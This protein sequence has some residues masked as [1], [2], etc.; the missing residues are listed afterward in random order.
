MKI[1]ALLLLLVNL[2][3]YAFSAGYLGG[4]SS[5][6]AGRLAQQV[7]P[8][9][10]VIVGHGDASASAKAENK[11]APASKADEAGS[12]EA[13][14]PEE[15][16]PEP[17][18]VEE[19]KATPPAEEPA[20]SESKP[21]AGDVAMTCRAWDKVTLADAEK[22]STA[23]SSKF[24]DYQ[25]TRKASGG[26]DGAAWWVYIPTLA[27]KAEADKKASELRLFGVGD[28]FVV[29]E[30]P[31]RNAIS[32]GI[33]S[34]EKG[35]QERLTEL[36]G[37]GVRSARVGARPGKEGFFLIEAYGPESGMARLA[38][39]V[40]KTLPKAQAQSCQ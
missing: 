23:T 4:Q 34:L 6:E 18:K 26:N 35:A 10:I 16:K 2:V 14:K 5:P 8:E 7:Q 21:V 33:F 25:W 29:Q 39:V 9:K 20:R 1:L 32:L 3:F 30:G 22:L 31:N 11:D 36:K 28:F 15:S 19:K 37:R 27:D 12:G 24:A 17:A 40:G 13:A 38:T